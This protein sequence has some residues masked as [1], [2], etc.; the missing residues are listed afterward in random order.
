MFE[1]IPTALAIRDANSS[2][3]SRG[4]S[5]RS[6]TTMSVESGFKEALLIRDN[7][8]CR[9]HGKNCQF[10][11][12]GDDSTFTAGHISSVGKDEQIEKI[13]KQG[14]THDIRNGYLWCHETEFCW[15]QHL[16]TI[17][18]ETGVVEFA[19]NFP[20][21]DM[22]IEK[23]EKIVIAKWQDKSKD[24][25]LD[26]EPPK[27]LIKERNKIYRRR[28]K[29]K[30][31]EQEKKKLSQKFE[32]KKCGRWFMDG[33]GLK[34]HQDGKNLECPCSVQDGELLPLIFRHFYI[35]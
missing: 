29:E 16:F 2:G 31:E 1:I 8:T 34:G 28:R 33:A 24:D 30:L 6:D 9:M 3:M 23:N 14:L 19:P 7:R 32:C 5:D 18:D 17:N 12:L 26:T 20:F 13:V 25:D 21:K 4:F 11:T 15:T 27:W 10:I 22:K 35:V